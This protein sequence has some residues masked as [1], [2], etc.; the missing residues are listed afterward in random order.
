MFLIIWSGESGN[1]PTKYI[2]SVNRPISEENKNPYMY[3]FKYVLTDGRTISSDRSGLADICPPLLGRY[4]TP[5]LERLIP[6]LVDY[7]LVMSNH[8]TIFI[9]HVPK[10]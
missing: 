7:S 5:N 6:I 9:A 4:F 1:H 10:V 2:I 8:L 3:P